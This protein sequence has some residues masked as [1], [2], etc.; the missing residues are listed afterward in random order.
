LL[1]VGGLSIVG[2]YLLTLTKPKDRQ[3]QLAELDQKA[4]DLA[5][6]VNAGTVW[7]NTYG[8]FFNQL[9]YG[10]CKQSG[11]GKE[12]GDQGLLEYTNLKNIVVDTTKDSKPLVNYWYG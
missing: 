5:T 9:S 10:G 7:I 11:F 12:L 2:Y 4:K 8:M 3:L 1:I 6:K